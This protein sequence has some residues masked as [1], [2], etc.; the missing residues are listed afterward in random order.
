MN[1]FIQIYR[2]Y[3][4]LNFQFYFIF[5]YVAYIAAIDSQAKEW[6]RTVS[7]HMPK[8]FHIQSKILQSNRTF[9]FICISLIRHLQTEY[10]YTH[11]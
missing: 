3:V 11:R 5:G 7:H 9:Y 2:S 6:R 1:S 4:F 8:G 10:K